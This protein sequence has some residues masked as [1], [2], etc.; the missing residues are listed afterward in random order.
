MIWNDNE[1]KQ[2]VV[3]LD[4]RVQEIS[5]VFNEDY[6]KLTNFVA[7]NEKRLQVLEKKGDE[8][9]LS[10]VHGRIDEVILKFEEYNTLFQRIVD[11]LEVLGIEKGVVEK[12]VKVTPKEQLADTIQK[13]RE[14]RAEDIKPQASEK[15]IT[16]WCIGCREYRRMKKETTMVEETKY[17]LMTSGA[18]EVCGRQIKNKVIQKRIRE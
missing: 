10:E 7:L 18:C 9:D 12:Q 13:F 6:Q 16:A 3:E 8:T 4:D 2:S 14:K 1:L 5:N 15:D 11:I 17:G